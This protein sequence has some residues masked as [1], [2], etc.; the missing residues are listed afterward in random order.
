[1]INKMKTIVI[2]RDNDDKVYQVYTKPEKMSYKKLEEKLKEFNSKNNCSARS[3]L[4][5]DYL[6]DA[7]EYLLKR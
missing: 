6:Y 4:L 5:P 3:E 7:F 2:L 1:M